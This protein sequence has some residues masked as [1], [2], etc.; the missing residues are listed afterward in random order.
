MRSVLGRL[1]RR[2]AVLLAIFLAAAQAG[3][4]D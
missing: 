3:S 1:T 2:A 4:V